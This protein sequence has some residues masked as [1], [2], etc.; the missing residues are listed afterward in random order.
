MLCEDGAEMATL[1]GRKL[2]LAEASS[3][4]DSIRDGFFWASKAVGIGAGTI[5][6]VEI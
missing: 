2:N 5:A 4:F 1:K 6:D 3:V